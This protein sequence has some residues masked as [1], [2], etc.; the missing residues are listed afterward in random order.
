M[1]ALAPHGSDYL[2]GDQRARPAGRA[3]PPGKAERI[4]EAMRVCVAARGAT[5]ATFDHVAREAGVSRGL[6]HYYFG[7]KE[8][9]LLEAV[10]REAEVRLDEFARS[11]TGARTAEDVLGALLATL[12]ALL[13][14]GRAAAVMFHEVITLAQRMPEVAAELAELSRRT[15]AHLAGVLREQVA[16]G[17]LAPEADPDATATVLL[18]IADGLVVRRLSEPDLPLEPVIQQAT[19]AARALLS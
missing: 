12:E 1:P 7:T 8:R 10:R 4:V 6:L 14:S 9:L 3:L 2:D 16:A 17:V 18:A 11:V 15:R 19:A 5:G 13:G